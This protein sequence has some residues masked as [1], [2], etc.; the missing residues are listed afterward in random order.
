[1]V[2][3]TKR[4]GYETVLGE[5]GSSSLTVHNRGKGAVGFEW[6]LEGKSGG[7]KTKA[8]HDGVQRFYFYHRKGVILPNTAFDFPIMFKSANPGIF[9]QRYRLVTTPRVPEWVDMTVT[10]QGIAIEPDTTL[11]KRLEIEKMLERR[12]ATTAATET[13]N[14]IF[15][16]LFRPRPAVSSSAGIDAKGM[17]KKGGEE[18]VF[19]RVNEGLHLYYTPKMYSEFTQIARDTWSV[20]GMVDGEWDGDV[21]RLNNLVESIPHVD[22]RSLHL[23]RLNDAVVEASVEPDGGKGNLLV[24]IGSD[25]L[26][27]LAD[28]IANISE[29]LRKEKGLPLVRSCSIFP[30]SEDTREDLPQ[31]HEDRRPSPPSNTAPAA[32]GGAAAA[33]P[34]PNVEAGKKG[35]AA[36]PAAKEPAGKKGA[37]SA[38][39]AGGK[40]AAGGGAG[41][42][43]GGGKGAAK[44]QKGGVE[45]PQ[46]AGPPADQEEPRNP[47]VLTKLSV[48]EKKP[49]SSR[50]WSR[51]RQ[52]AEAEYKREFKQMVHGLVDAAITRMCALFDDAD[53]GDGGE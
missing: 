23:R 20:L 51:E 48:R 53:A 49:D 30:I 4:L 36:A 2:F 26:M 29:E 47:I 7:L 1:L 18:E 13:I 33:N 21:R 22:T 27:D 8:V 25:I 46:T 15:R 31:T 34:V 28:E 50:G 14:T 41:G 24:V 12:Q 39:A 43:G 42:G 44:G 5:V 37:A 9:T 6:V 32:G 52:L 35:G 11:S 10:L 16:N 45:V 38:A 17:K 40:V 19:E 3:P